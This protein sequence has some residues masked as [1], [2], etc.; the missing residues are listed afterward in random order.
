M[1]TTTTTPT[2]EPDLTTALL[3]LLE[4]ARQA[5]TPEQLRAVRTRWQHLADVVDQHATRRASLL[6][7]YI[8]VGTQLTRALDAAGHH[9]ECGSH[10]DAQRSL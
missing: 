4:H 6:G 7:L 5:S 8:W 10:T 2:T 9:P 1:T 3:D